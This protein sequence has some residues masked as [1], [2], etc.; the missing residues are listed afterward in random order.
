[1]TKE[2]EDVVLMAL[3]KKWWQDHRCEEIKYPSM[4]CHWETN[5]RKR[6]KV[7]DGYFDELAERFSILGLNESVD[8]LEVGGLIGLFD[9]GLEMYYGVTDTG[10][11]R[12]AELQKSAAVRQ[13]ALSY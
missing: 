9:T 13:A 10:L 4:Y 6:S 3:Y 7:P 2:S 12:I 11:A 5:D 8:S 1:M